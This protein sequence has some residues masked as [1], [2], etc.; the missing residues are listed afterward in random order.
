MKDNVILKIIR[1]FRKPHIIT[2]THYSDGHI[3]VS[4]SNPNPLTRRTEETHVFKTE[5]WV[6]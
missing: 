1:K 3:G 5:R 4:D 6:K 2:Y